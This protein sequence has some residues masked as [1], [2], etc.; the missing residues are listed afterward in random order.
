MPEWVIRVVL[1]AYPPLPG[2]PPQ[3]ISGRPSD[4]VV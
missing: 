4:F 3:P 1:A 2:Y